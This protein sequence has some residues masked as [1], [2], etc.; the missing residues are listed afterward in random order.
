MRLMK[1]VDENSLGF[2]LHDAARLMRKRFEVRGKDFGLSSAQWR[3]LFRLMREGQATQ[4]RLAEL[5]EIEPISVSR[6]LD[7][8]ADAGWVERG[9]DPQDRRVNIV[10]PTEMATSTFKS[11][12]A[13]ADEVYDEA[14][15]GM[16]AEDR[17]QLVRAL[18][19][20][21]ANLSAIETASASC[22]PT[23]KDTE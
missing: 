11:I 21:A 7:R 5:L 9:K 12:R 4:A 10:T 22:P 2:L 8:M 13:M 1:T 14:M 3:L 18:A 16:T 17:Q 6:L 15:A 19:T 23:G 20:M